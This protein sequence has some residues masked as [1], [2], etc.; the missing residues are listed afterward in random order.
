MYNTVLF[1]LD[2]TL[3]DS[4]PGI[5]NSVIYALKKMGIEETDREKLHA[6]IGPPLMESFAKYYGFDHE[7]C[8]T[9]LVN[10]R[11]Y[12]SVDGKFENDVYEGIP[13]VL[14]ELKAQG[15]RLI[16]ATSKP[17]LFARQIIEHFDLDKYF[18]FVGGASMDETRNTKPEVIKY[19]LS[20]CGITDLDDVVMIGDRHHDVEGAAEFGIKTVGVLFGYGSLDELKDAG[21]AYIAETPADILKCIL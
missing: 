12:F 5:I 9:A 16:V 2:G 18:D 15:K 14:E 11:E 20:E 4:A 17:E 8:L 1:D 6:F 13:E 7:T 21:A 19:A 3:T 10:Y